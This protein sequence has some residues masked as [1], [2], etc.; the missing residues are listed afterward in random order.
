MKSYSLI[1]LLFIAPYLVGQEE[2]PPDSSR[3]RVNKAVIYYGDQPAEPEQKINQFKVQKK[4]EKGTLTVIEEDSLQLLID[5]YREQKVIE[6]Y[7]IQLFSGRSRME[8]V[9]IKS[10]FH[11]KFGD[12]ESADIVYQQPNFKIRVGNYRD[13]LAAHK[14][15]AVYK[16]DF[17]SSFIV[18][19]V[20]KID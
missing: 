9:K 11:S 18:K 8:A 3:S 10:S 15:L 17:P 16:V 5:G 2:L 20:I 14:W 19:D 1:L 13:R 12:S 4:K 6:G 7:K